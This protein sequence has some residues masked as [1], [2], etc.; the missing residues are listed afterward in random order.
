MLPVLVFIPHFPTLTVMIKTLAQRMTDALLVYVRALQLFV[1]EMMHAMSPV[2]V[3]KENAATSRDLTILLVMITTCVLDFLPAKVVFALD[4]NHL[5]APLNSV[6]PL[7]PASLL[8]EH[9]HMSNSKM[10][11]IAMTTTLAL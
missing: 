11:L 9:V 1:L 2:Y 3:L 6:L 7:E 4:Y 10:K 5:L 8:T